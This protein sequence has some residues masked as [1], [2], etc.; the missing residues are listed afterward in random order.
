MVKPVAAVF[1]VF[2]T[3]IKIEERRD[4]YLHLL[5]HGRTQG[6]SLSREK[7]EMLMTCE[8]D[9][10]DAASA[11]AIRVGYVKLHALDRLLNEELA[12]M[13]LY[14][15]AH[16]AIALLQGTGIKVGLCSNLASGYGPAV[17]EL[18]PGLD[19]YGFS[20]EI[21]AMKPNPI[22]YQSVCRDLGGQPGQQLGGDRVVMIGDSIRCDRDGARAAGL[23][24]FHL[25]RTG[26]GDFSNLI[27]FAKAA[28]NS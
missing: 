2:G 12:S 15:D 9:W 11:L 1:D 7:V 24:G 13:T 16:E 27:E 20:Y 3:L 18:L 26:R 5:R 8:L 23:A 19:A 17:R 6:A 10:E 25:S 28:L 4:P 14:P 21:G 22:I